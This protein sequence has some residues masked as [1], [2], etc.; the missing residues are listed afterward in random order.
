M[1]LIA[2]GIAITLVGA[3]LWRRP[4]YYYRYLHSTSI[5]ADLN[6]RPPEWLVKFGAGLTVVVGVVLGG[7]A[8]SQ[9][10]R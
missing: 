10:A 1:A 5:W 6:R 8:V 9:L 7:V 4:Q 3:F 2:A